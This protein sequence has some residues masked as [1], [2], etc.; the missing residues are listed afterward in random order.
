[1]NVAS[2]PSGNIGFAV[3]SVELVIVV[4]SL[5]CLVVVSNN[6]SSEAT[7]RGTAVRCEVRGH[8][9]GRAE[10]AAAPEQ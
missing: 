2:A 3:L 4:C 8:M 7:T 5:P 9:V 6:T 10:A 1:M